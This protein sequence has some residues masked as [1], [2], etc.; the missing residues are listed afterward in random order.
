MYKLRMFTN[1]SIKDEYKP[2][3]IVK[4]GF[5]FNSINKQHKAVNA[6]SILR[7][8]LLTILDTPIYKITKN[9]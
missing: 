1:S 7:E 5:E 6:Y 4:E 9:D 8:R 2:A 3:F